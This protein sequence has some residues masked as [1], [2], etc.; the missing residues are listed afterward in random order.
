[1]S[2]FA[3]WKLLVSVVIL[4]VVIC[5]PVAVVTSVGMLQANIRIPSKCDRLTLSPVSGHDI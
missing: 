2:I 5:Y 3:T 4:S 1:M